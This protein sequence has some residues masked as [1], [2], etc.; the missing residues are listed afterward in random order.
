MSGEELEIELRLPSAT[1]AVM[2]SVV[3]ANV[4][5]DLRRPNLP[6]GMGVRF[7]GHSP[8][9]RKLLNDYVESRLARLDV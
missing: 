2:G 3:F 4:S 9:D 1:L 6:V 5:G 7:K 8:A